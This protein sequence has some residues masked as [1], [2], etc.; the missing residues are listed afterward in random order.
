LQHII[1]YQEISRIRGR[2]LAR[3]LN[4]SP[5]PLG[6]GALGVAETIAMSGRLG[7]VNL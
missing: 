2:D 4:Q 6:A 1:V 7:N 3:S 5:D